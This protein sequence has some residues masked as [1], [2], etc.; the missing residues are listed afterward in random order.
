[1]DDFT[2][3]I[4]AKLVDLQESVN[5][6]EDDLSSSRNV[7]DVLYD[8]QGIS[9]ELSNIID[10]TSGNLSLTNIDTTIG[11][12]DTVSR[13][14]FFSVHCIHTNAYIQHTHL[15]FTCSTNTAFKGALLAYKW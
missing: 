9:E 14:F 10:A 3:C 8:L 4:N 15:L 12:I 13:L 6:L 1:V 11:I 5:K 2:Q 7:V